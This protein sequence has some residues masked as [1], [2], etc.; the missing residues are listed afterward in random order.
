[1]SHAADTSS[2]R[3]NSP[4]RQFSGATSSPAAN[5]G[6]RTRLYRFTVK[7]RELQFLAY[8]VPHLTPWAAGGKQARDP[9]GECL[10]TARGGTSRQTP[11][12]ATR[13]AGNYVAHPL[14]SVC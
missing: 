1:M 7:P 12:H 5:G 3:R 10:A 8:P 4:R 6:R 9:A 2:H 14:V 11:A 13:A